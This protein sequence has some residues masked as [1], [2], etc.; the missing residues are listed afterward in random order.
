MIHVIFYVLECH[1]YA[2]Y[3]DGCCV[4][5][6]QKTYIRDSEH[7]SESFVFP[8]LFLLLFIVWFC[9]SFF[10]SS[11]F[12][13]YLG[14]LFDQNVLFDWITHIDFK[15]HTLKCNKIQWQIVLKFFSSLVITVWRTVMHYII[16]TFSCTLIGRLVTIVK[17]NI[18]S[19]KCFKIWKPLK[20]KKKMFSS[21]AFVWSKNQM[22]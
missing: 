22:V 19:T 13:L 11:I 12:S 14:C 7:F 8:C 2:Y 15:C 3:A 20:D 5:H 17:R 6:K 16:C 1:L 4:F 9:V 18:L 10:R 21:L